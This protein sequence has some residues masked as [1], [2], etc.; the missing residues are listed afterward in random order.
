M[1]T[2]S[3]LVMNVCRSDSSGVAK[4]SQATIDFGDNLKPQAILA[5]GIARIYVRLVS[6]SVSEEMH[7]RIKHLKLHRSTRCN[8]FCSAVER[9]FEL[10]FL[11]E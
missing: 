8:H 11:S 4:K 5:D 7:L 6:K 2:A 3:G 1:E 9:Q 10:L